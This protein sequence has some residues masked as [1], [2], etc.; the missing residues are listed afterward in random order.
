MNFE[1]NEFAA[2]YKPY[3]EKANV[4][5]SIIDGL[6]ENSKEVLAFFENLPVEKL[7]YRYAEGKW[8]PKDILLHLI[9]AER[10]FT[11]RALRIARNDKS[12][13][14]GFEEND[15]VDEASANFRVLS[16]LI[17]EFK[18]VR[19]STISLYNSFNDEQLKRVGVASNSSVSVRA[20]AY[21]TIGHYMHHIQ[22]INERYL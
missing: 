4:Y 5:N 13:L 22:L 11:Y 18:T 7:E 16:D 15:Y 8:T 10:I 17:E 2:Y 6:N 3:I 21:M 19:S 1:A 20:L 14:P 9:D 12:E